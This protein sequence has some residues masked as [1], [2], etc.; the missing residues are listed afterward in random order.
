MADAVK[1]IDVAI[2]EFGAEPVAWRY[3]Y[4]KKGITDSQ[5]EPWVGDWKYMPTKEDCNDRPSYEIQALYASPPAPVVPDEMYWQDAPVE[6]STRAAAYAT[7]W[8]ACCRAAMI[9]A[10]NSPVT[11]DGWTIVPKELTCEM[12]DAAWEAY[13]ETRCMSD[14]WA[15]LLSAAPKQEVR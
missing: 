6:G 14:I 7:G 9:Q 1:L 2:A 11:P 3:R 12:D 15:A 10:G 5:G 13:H 8:N 4:V